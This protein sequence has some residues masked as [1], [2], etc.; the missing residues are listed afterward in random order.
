MDGTHPRTHPR[1][2]QGDYPASGVCRHCQGPFKPRGAWQHFCS[3]PCRREWHKANKGRRIRLIELERRVAD[4]E[5][6]MT[7]LDDPTA[8]EAHG[9]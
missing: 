5:R 7:V 9:G 3:T 2:P 8:K 4:L 6:R 1:V